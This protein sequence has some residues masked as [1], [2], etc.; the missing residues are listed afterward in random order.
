MCVQYG[1]NSYGVHSQR[2]GKDEQD[3]ST[4]RIYKLRFNKSIMNLKFNIIETQ[5]KKF[6]SNINVLK[7]NDI[8]FTKRC[9]VKNARLESISNKC[10][11]I[12]KK[13]QVQNDELED[14]FISQINEQLE[15]IKNHALEIGDNTNLFVIQLARSESE[16]YNLKNEVIEHVDQICK[17]YEPNSHIPRHHTP[18]TEE[19]PSVKECLTPFL[20]ENV[21]SAG[22]ML[23]V[24]EW[25]KLSGEG[26]YNH[27]ELIIKIDIL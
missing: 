21:I 12:E 16:R 1:L 3:F 10:D 24:E 15:V 27:I 25:R 19:K 7:N 17:N 13:I 2:T 6:T 8:N 22:D 26:E 5:L 20:D 18:L 11:I 23:K 4:K 14:L 9:Q